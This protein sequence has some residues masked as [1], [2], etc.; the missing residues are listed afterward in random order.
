M[1]GRLR[2]NVIRLVT[3]GTEEVS[4]V[5]SSARPPLSIIKTNSVDYHERRR[6][7]TAAVG[8]IG[9]GA[10]LPT[11]STYLCSAP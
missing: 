10:S 1:M 11:A 2:S 6:R 9:E 8:G 4:K 5:S 3:D 7:A